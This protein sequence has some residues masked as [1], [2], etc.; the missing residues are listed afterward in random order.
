[1]LLNASKS[2]RE[3]Y[4]TLFISTRRVRRIRS[5]SFP[6]RSSI[7]A[8]DSLYFSP[9]MATVLPE[10][11]GIPCIRPAASY[12]PLTELS[13]PFTID[14]ASRSYKHQYANIYFVRL[15]EQ[16]PAVEKKA[17]EKWKD[18]KG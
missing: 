14:P 4:V 7:T 2:N 15:V 11:E 9:A 5:R 18:V 3:Y 16:R 8:Y 10:P 12:D 13:K 6:S 1:M 17:T